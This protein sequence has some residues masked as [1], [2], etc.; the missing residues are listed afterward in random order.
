M[1]KILS[2]TIAIIALLSS[3][4]VTGPLPKVS[5]PASV[6]AGTTSIVPVDPPPV[7]LQLDPAAEA[8]VRHALVNSPDLERTA[9]RLRELRAFGKAADA[10]RWPA[11]SA[12]GG[13]SAINDST[14]DLDDGRNEDRLRRVDKSIEFRWEIDL[15]GKLAADRRAAHAERWAAAADLAAARVILAHSVRSEIVRYRAAVVEAQLVESSLTTLRDIAAL[16][17]QLSAAGL[18][19]GVDLSQ[20][21]STIAAQEADLVALR[22]ESELTPL[23]LRTLGD[24]P[25]AE[26]HELS[27][28]K[29]EAPECRMKSPQVLSAEIPL[30]WLQQR[31]DVAAAESRL[32]AGVA[33]TESA[34]A[35]IYPSFALV[36]G[37]S[38][39]RDRT[40]NLGQL[41]ARSTQ[42]F[43]GV[44]IAATLFDAGQRASEARAA[45]ARAEAAA[46]DFRHTVL[47]AAEEIEG[48]LARTTVSDA[49]SLASLNARREAEAAALWGQQRQQA[50]IDSRLT[51]LQLQRDALE[52]ALQHT[53]LERDRCLAALDLSRALGLIEPRSP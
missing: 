10:S 49:A 34:R 4:C 38:F 53:A 13:P 32:L 47:L 14:F 28:P 5:M 36:A 21:R 27:V 16:E 50:G 26:I 45:Q 24:I 17:A 29:D 20:L 15:F 46:A 51:A 9:A 44:S 35:A 22:L 23:R 30:F 7:A 11:L 42:Q 2:G 12:H 25:L 41:L 1:S 3:G 33:E 52:R 39:K 8:A 6:G 37:R 40:R 48:A 18:R 19:S 43:I 31:L